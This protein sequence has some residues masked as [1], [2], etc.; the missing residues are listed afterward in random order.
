MPTINS[1]AVEYNY[2][3]AEARRATFA[4][5][6]TLV[7]LHGFTGSTESW[8]EHLPIFSAYYRT[9]AIDLLG[10][11]RT[12]APADF[13]RYDMEQSASDLADL[14]TTIAPGPIHLLGYS[15]GGRLALYFAVTYPY[16]VHSLV[17]ESASPGL[18]DP[19]ARQ[20]RI[21]SDEQLANEIE[22]Q[23][24]SAFVARW[25][26]LP[27][28]AGQQRLPTAVQNRLRDQRLGNRPHGLANSLRGMGTGRQPALWD[29]LATL[30]MPTLL[31]AGELDEKFKLI[32]R[33]M[34]TYLPNATVAIVPDAGHTIHLEQPQ[35]FQEQVLPFLHAAALIPP[36]TQMA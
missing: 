5:P 2:E 3:V 15:M 35:A 25:E 30:S 18:A 14:L 29:Q 8:A 10:H 20:E 16:L 31:L 32:A 1:N 17:L 19:V 36:D 23:G 9:I 26:A 4:Q 13:A 11:G 27:L 12:E 7:L 28:F 21:Q 34:A 6:Q 24:I 22:A 33:Q